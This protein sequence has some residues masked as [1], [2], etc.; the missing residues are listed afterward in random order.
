MS[1]GI[2]IKESI[3]L[4]DIYLYKKDYVFYGRLDRAIA[5]LIG[6]G[7]VKSEYTDDRFKDYHDY[8]MVRGYRKAVNTLYDKNLIKLVRHLKLPK[9]P[10]IV[11]PNTYNSEL[12][13][14]YFRYSKKLEE[15][16]QEFN[17]LLDHLYRSYTI[18]SKKRTIAYILNWGNITEKEEKILRVRLNKKSSGWPIRE[19]GKKIVPPKRGLEYV[20]IFIT[21]ASFED[22]CT[23][24][25]EEIS[26]SARPECSFLF[27]DTA[28]YNLKVDDN[29]REIDKKLNK[30]SKEVAIIKCDFNNVE[31]AVNIF[32]KAC[33]ELGQQLENKVIFVD[34][35]T[36]S[37]ALLLG[38]L[39]VVVNG[40]NYVINYYT[41]VGDY[42]VRQSYGEYKIQ[43]I[44]QFTSNF[45]S[46]KKNLLVLFAGFEEDR[47]ESSIEQI[48]PDSTILLI[49]GDVRKDWVKRALKT[50]KAIE[51]KGLELQY[52]STLDNEKVYEQLVHIYNKHHNK[53]NITIL[54]IG[55]KIEVLGIY[56]FQKDFSDVKILIAPPEDHSKY[57][58][59]YSIGSGDIHKIPMN[60]ICKNSK[61]EII[62][63]YV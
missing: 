32:K 63:G 54:P 59:N 43:P 7:F 41:E 49:G 30:I 15:E 47:T 10:T 4:A 29:L 9:N 22:R 8:L 62:V 2:S 27:V 33:S 53:D 3:L 34:D 51:G 52:T 50:N 6:K 14:V 46:N 39:P 56:E 44:N 45:S 23:K 26:V 11:I 38:L 57:D 35:S 21:S 18:A 19:V 58:I 5:C 36:F 20:D 31:Q 48:D 42:G 60:S 1:K 12:K 28:T 13:N 61:N 55:S 25:T 17:E 24:V 40:R 37:K 16:L